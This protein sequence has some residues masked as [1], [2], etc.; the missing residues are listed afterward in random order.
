MSFPN[1]LKDL[2]DL[3]RQNGIKYKGK[4]KAQLKELLESN[5]VTLAEKN[6]AEDISKLSVRALKEKCDNLGL[7]KCGNKD[8]LIKRIISFT[9][10]IDTGIK[11]VQWKKR[12]RKA[13]TRPSETVGVESEESDDDDEPSEYDKMKK[14]E[15]KEECIRRNLP[16]SGNVK[17]IINRLKEND[18]LKDEVRRTNP[19]DDK[20]RESCEENPGKLYE[21]PSA[22]WFC[23]D[24]KQHICNL[25]KD[26][27]EKLKITRTHIIIPFGTILELNIGNDLTIPGEIVPNEIAKAKDV[28]QFMDISRSDDDED[29]IRD[30]PKKRKRTNDSETDEDENDNSLVY[31]TPLA[32]IFYRRNKRVVVDIIPET[33]FNV[34]ETPDFVDKTLDDIDETPDTLDN[35]N[36]IPIITPPPVWRTPPAR[37]KTTLFAQ[38]SPIDENSFT[39]TYVAESPDRLEI[40]KDMFDDSMN[41]STCLVPETPVLPP[42]PPPVPTQRLTDYVPTFPITP[43]RLQGQRWRNWGLTR[44]RHLPPNEVYTDQEVIDNLEGNN[45]APVDVDSIPPNDHDIDTSPAL[46]EPIG[47]NVHDQSEEIPQ[48]HSNEVVVEPKKTITAKITKEKK[49]NL[50]FKVP[51]EV[52]SKCL[53]GKWTYNYQGGE[54]FCVDGFS[55]LINNHC[56]S[57]KTG[58]LTLYLICSKCGGRN[59]LSDGVLKKH[60]HPGHTCSPDPDNWA[61]L[62]ADLHLKSLGE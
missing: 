32:R 55:Y 37:P 14:H 47:N 30:T 31:E 9:S 53:N 35:D 57:K 51:E 49:R 59:I 6:D 5:N 10:N 4:T 46:E 34:P 45:Q 1:T 2:N 23:R 40:S 13:A 29:C 33:S 17:T 7:S 21:S 62:E 26:A 61:I 16:A 60:D 36:E 15:L 19:N 44:L 25:C 41:Q 56:V 20:L 38:I 11:V 48:S 50:T 12:G 28:P 22:K 39:V 18:E 27:H 52:K 8:E 42:N 43:A 24:C 58:A 54:T 3:C